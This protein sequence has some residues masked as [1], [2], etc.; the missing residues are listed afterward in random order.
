MG[1]KQSAYLRPLRW[2]FVLLSVTSMA[3]WFWLWLRYVVMEESCRY[4]SEYAYS[5]LTGF[6]SA[7]I[8][9]NQRQQGLVGA[10]SL[11]GLVKLLQVLKFPLPL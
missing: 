10:P 3:K 8:S 7:F 2:F 11:K 9:E 5:W 4:F 1:I 6:K